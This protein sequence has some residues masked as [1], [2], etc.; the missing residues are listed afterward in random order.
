LIVTGTNLAVELTESMVQPILSLWSPSVIFPDVHKVTMSMF[1]VDSAQIMP[2]GNQGCGK[3]T[4]PFF[5]I[6]HLGINLLTLELIG[7]KKRQTMA[8]YR[9]SGT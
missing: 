1:T 7:S 5:K 6:K 3:L 9:D 8:I 4:I 2:K